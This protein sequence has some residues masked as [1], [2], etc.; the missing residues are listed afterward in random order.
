MAKLKTWKEIPIGGLTEAGSS[1][2]FLTGSWR[3]ERPI[4]NKEKCINC[5]LCWVV[6]PDMS[7]VVK[8]G[9]VTGMDLDYCK[10][11]G[12]CAS[13]CPVKA[14]TMEPETKFQK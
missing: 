9:K 6:C 1:A 2:R 3:V 13:I 14:I 8:D 5:M 12:A 11:C 10:G 4:F 7:I